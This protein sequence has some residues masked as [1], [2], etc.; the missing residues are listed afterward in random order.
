MDT[1]LFHGVAAM[2]SA[3]RQLESIAHNLANSDTPAYKRRSTVTQ[4]FRLERNGSGDE[5]P[6]TSQRID[7]A[8]GQ[9]ERTQ[10]ATHFA[11]DGQGFFAVEGPKGEV[12][13]RNGT[14]RLDNTGVLQTTEGYPVA[15]QGSTGAIDPVGEPIRVETDGT[16]R[17]GVKELGKLKLAGFDDLEALS[18]NE[19]GYWVAPRGLQPGE[20]DAAVLQGV[21]EG[22]NTSSIDE[23]VAMIRVQRSFESSARMLAMIDESY[24][25]L[26]S[27]S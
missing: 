9:L 22:S 11:L 18:Q 3:E 13:T 2:R 26:T 5:Q 19:L 14:F 6:R 24:Q 20:S 23:L 27:R 25:R 17:Q 1:S 8:Q 4:T 21:L 10:I 15:W 12:Y 16:V 7:F